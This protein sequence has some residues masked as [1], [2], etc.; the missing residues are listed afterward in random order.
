MLNV[1]VRFCSS[2]FS[3][4]THGWMVLSLFFSGSS[5]SNYWY[6]NFSGIYL[7]LWII[8]K[9]CI[10]HPSKKKTSFSFIISQ[11]SVFKVSGLRHSNEY[12]ERANV[13]YY[14]ICLNDQNKFQPTTLHIMQRTLSWCV[15]IWRK[16]MLYTDMN[17][18]I[19]Y[20]DVIDLNGCKEI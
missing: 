2:F 8:M 10:V 4:S 12:S 1:R 11:V 9:W 17:K 3:Y 20:L 15:L 6:R 18:F 13:G 5:T 19:S 16:S 7:V 14:A